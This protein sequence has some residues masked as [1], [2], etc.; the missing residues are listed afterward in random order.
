MASAAFTERHVLVYAVIGIEFG[1]ILD[2]DTSPA[3]IAA[4]LFSD[5]VH[6][7]HL[8]SPVSS[9]FILAASCLSLFRM[10]KRGA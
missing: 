5:F 6:V 8:Y 1:I 10:Q 9:C 2:I 3:N 7:D 4:I